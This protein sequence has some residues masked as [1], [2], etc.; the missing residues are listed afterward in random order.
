MMTVRFPNGHAIQYNNATWLAWDPGKWVLKESEKGKPIAFIQASAGVI[1]EFASP[2][3]VYDGIQQNQ[4]SELVKEVKSVK[5]K[6]IIK[7]KNE[8]RASK[9]R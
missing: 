4:L 8:K 2:C 5:R 1:V 9:N 6:I 7:G 3:R